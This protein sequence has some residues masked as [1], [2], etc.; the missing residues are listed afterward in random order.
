MLRIKTADSE[1]TMVNSLLLSSCHDIESVFVSIKLHLLVLKSCKDKIHITLNFFHF[2]TCIKWKKEFF[3]TKHFPKY[4]IHSLFYFNS[5][6]V[7]LLDIWKNGRSCSTQLTHTICCLQFCTWH[8]SPQSI[9]LQ[10]VAVYHLVCSKETSRKTFGELQLL[11]LHPRYCQS[12][13]DQKEKKSLQWW[14]RKV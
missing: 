10:S 11:Y 6:L 14:Q 3:K 4:A 13:I 8:R 9:Q 12:V 2:Y 5:V 1:D 7:W